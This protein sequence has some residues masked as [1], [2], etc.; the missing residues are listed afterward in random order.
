MLSWSGI[1]T[2]PDCDDQNETGRAI[3][4][5]VCFLILSVV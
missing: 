1:E 4:R 2:L 3:A 5:P